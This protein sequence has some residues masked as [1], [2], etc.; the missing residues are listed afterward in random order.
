MG[1]GKNVV[2]GGFRAT[3]ALVISIIALAFALLSYNRAGTDADLKAEIKGLQKKLQEVTKDTSE[4]LDKVRA[5]T[6][7]ALEKLGMCFGDISMSRGRGQI[8]SIP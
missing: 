3:I 8:I 1:T 7:A 4:R 6:G 5:E 2:K